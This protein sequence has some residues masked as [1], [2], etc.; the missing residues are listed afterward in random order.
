MNKLIIA[1]DLHGTLLNDDW[2]IKIEHQ[3]ELA[4]IIDDF[5]NYADFYICTGNNY[6]FVERYVPKQILDKI[7]GC[8]LETGCLIQQ[9]NVKNCL[10][11][12]E[13]KEKIKILQAFLEEKKYPFVK[14]FAKRE[15][16]ISIFT[17][18]EHTGENPLNFYQVV[19]DDLTRHPV[20][21]S[22]YLTFSNVALDIIPVGFNKWN[23]LKN[24][25]Q[26]CNIISF[27]DS[28]NDKDI[29][30]QSYLTFLPGNASDRLISYL[31]N[32]NK[33][34]FKFDK[35]HITKNHVY[36]SEKLSTHAV[37]DGLKILKNYLRDLK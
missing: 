20:G 29:A 9:D 19:Y 12:E 4:E 22:V 1:L 37:I 3:N 18:D 6:D 11:T 34:I 2:M 23:T 14:Y 30:R 15:T 8:I 21:D 28:Y 7:K 33:L 24:L 10:T 25:S 16:T 36:I 17:R 31:R 32:E 35:F 13:T 5:V 27:M 26:D